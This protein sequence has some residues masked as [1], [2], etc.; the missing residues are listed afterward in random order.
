MPDATQILASRVLIVDDNQ[1]NVLLLERLLR[2][3]GYALVT[4]TMDPQEVCDLHR[5]NRY[6]LILLDLQMPGRDGFRVLADLK[7][8]D[9]DGRPSVLVMSA[10]PANEPQARE[11]GAS[12]FIS[13]PFNTVEVLNRVYN[14][15]EQR[16]TWVS[17]GTESGESP[18][19]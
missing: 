4:S 16:L 13:K 1:S 6:D 5:K 18:L 9:E 10:H 11:A 7:E 15:L 19:R 8:I 17:P 2:G 12:D 14:V 3:A